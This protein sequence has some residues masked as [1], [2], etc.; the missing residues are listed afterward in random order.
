MGD[1]TWHPTAYRSHTLGQIQSIGRELVDEEV[2]ICGFAEAI[3]GKGKICFLDLRD[4]TG[5][6]QIFLKEGNVEDETLAAVQ[7]ASRES[8]IK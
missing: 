3:R 4:G 8:T 2:T 6:C 7:N 5:R 1:T